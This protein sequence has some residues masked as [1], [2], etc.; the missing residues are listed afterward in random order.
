M[1]TAIFSALQEL[2]A[3]KPGAAGPGVGG[4]GGPPRPVQ[5]PAA[6]GRPAPVSSLSRCRGPSGSTGLQQTGACVSAARCPGPSEGHLLS[7]LLLSQALPGLGHLAARHACTP[8]TH[9]SAGRRWGRNERPFAGRG[10]GQA[11]PC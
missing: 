10:G 2:S 6:A 7:A 11:G 4:C 9:G 3:K 1:T 5:G 8:L